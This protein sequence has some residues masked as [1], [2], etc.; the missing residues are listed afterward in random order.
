M[1][2]T[3]SWALSPSFSLAIRTIAGEMSQPLQRQPRSSIGIRLLPVPQPTSRR[4][5]PMSP[6]PS[7]RGSTSTSHGS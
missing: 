1:S 5:L 4:L 7:S 2:A 3:V 6:Q